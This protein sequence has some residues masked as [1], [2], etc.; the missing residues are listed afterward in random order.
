MLNLE[1]DETGLWKAKN[2]EDK[3][4]IKILKTDKFPG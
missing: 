1:E 4:N 2:K 3:T